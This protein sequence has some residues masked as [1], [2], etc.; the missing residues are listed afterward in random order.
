MAPQLPTVI[1][2]GPSLNDRSRFLIKNLDLD[3]KK[4]VRRHDIPH[5]LETGF[6]GNIILVDGVFQQ[7][8]AVGHAEIR[9]ALS[10]NCKVY[11]LS[12]IGAIRAYEMRHMGMHGF[13]EVYSFFER[14]EDF[15]DDEVALLHFPLPPFTPLCEPLVH[16]RVCVDDL[17]AK[18]VFSTEAGLQ[19]IHRLKERYFGERTLDLFFELISQQNSKFDLSSLRQAFDQYRIKQIDLVRFLES[20]EWLQ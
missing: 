20:Q 6:Q 4:P 19:I 14:E 7:D 2:A 17:I 16:C 13:G 9:E 11:G 10:K 12:S 3:L 15:Q 1:F 5:L 8:L 18:D